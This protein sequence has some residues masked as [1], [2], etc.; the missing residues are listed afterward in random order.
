VA[1]NIPVWYGEFALS[2]Q[3]QATEE[4]L[5]KWADAQKLMYSKGAGWL[6]RP[7]APYPF[8]FNISNELNNRM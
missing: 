8:H 6:V 2:T 3:F 5:H 4:F 7:S 1:G